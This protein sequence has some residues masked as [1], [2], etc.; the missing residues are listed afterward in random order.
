MGKWRE[1]ARIVW[2]KKIPIMHA[3]GYKIIMRPVLIYGSET[4]ALRKA[5]LLLER[6]EMRM[7]RW[8]I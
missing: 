3:A 4:L 2:A 1:M 5:V 7:L 6:T 8:M